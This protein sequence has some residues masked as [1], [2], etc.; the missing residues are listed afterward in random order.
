MMGKENASKMLDQGWQPTG[1]EAKQIGEIGE[2]LCWS[3]RNAGN[4]LFLG[5]VKEVVPHDKLL[6]RC[7]ELGEQ[8]AKEGKKK[9]I[10]GGDKQL[11]IFLVGNI[12]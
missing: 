8:W 5:L 3:I 4:L 11:Q 6:Q 10:P 9:E 1:A 2:Y 7:Q 12:S